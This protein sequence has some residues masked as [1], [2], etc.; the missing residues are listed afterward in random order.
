MVSVCWGTANS[1]KLFRMKHNYS[2]WTFLEFKCE[3][4]I[5][6]GPRHIFLERL[7]FFSHHVRVLRKSGWWIVGQDEIGPYLW[8]SFPKIG[9]G[10]KREKV[11]LLIKEPWFRS[12]ET[13][14]FYYWYNFKYCLYKNFL[15]KDKW[16]F[17][18]TFIVVT[19]FYVIAFWI[20]SSLKKIQQ[21]IVMGYNPSNHRD[22]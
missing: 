18:K 15:F 11:K 22:P 8:K 19:Y 13:S 20:K 14:Y 10:P 17:Q 2:G 9:L 12:F 5:H 7:K 3:C 4:T 16:I 1:F 21:P 6:N